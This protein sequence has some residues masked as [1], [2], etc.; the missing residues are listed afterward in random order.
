MCP[1]ITM[2]PTAKLSE[3]VIWRD[4]NIPVAFVVIVAQAVRV[5]LLVRDQK[6]YDK[7]RI[8]A[9]EYRPIQTHLEMPSMVFQPCSATRNAGEDEM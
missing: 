2:F 3:R 1:V 7:V 9:T 5:S 8:L 4:F 6:C